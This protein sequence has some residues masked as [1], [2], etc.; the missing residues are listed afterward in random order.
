MRQM[1]S[2]A[3]STNGVAASGRAGVSVITAAAAAR[4]SQRRMVLVMESIRSWKGCC[5]ESRS[6][7]HRGGARGYAA[8]ARPPASAGSFSIFD[9]VTQTLPSLSFADTV[10]VTRAFTWVV[11]DS[12]ACSATSFF[13]T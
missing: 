12:P 5:P 2:P 4:D 13:L 8:P 6:P 7:P 9:G 11:H 10:P 1:C 3:C